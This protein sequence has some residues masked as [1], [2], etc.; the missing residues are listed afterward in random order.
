MNEVFEQECERL[1]HRVNFY[2]GIN[3]WDDII[4]AHESYSDVFTSMC[5]SVYK[6]DRFVVMSDIV[7]NDHFL[8]AY[9]YYAYQQHCWKFREAVVEEFEV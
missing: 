1:L 5:D 6:N 8:L 3:L 2:D 4:L 9:F 7:E